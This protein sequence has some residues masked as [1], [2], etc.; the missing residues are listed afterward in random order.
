MILN[1]ARKRWIA[2]NCAAP[3]LLRQCLNAVASRPLNT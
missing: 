1:H 2:R 3:I